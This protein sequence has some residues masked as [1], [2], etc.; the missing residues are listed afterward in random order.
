MRWEMT[1]GNPIT[2]VRQC[3]R[4]SGRPPRSHARSVSGAAEIASL[5]WFIRETSWTLGNVKTPR[6]PSASDRQPG[7]PVRPQAEAGRAARLDVVIRF[8]SSFR[9]WLAWRADGYGGQVQAAALDR[10]RLRR[11]RRARRRSA[12]A[13]RER[14]RTRRS[15][16]SRA[17]GVPLRARAAGP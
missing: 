6:A 9:K 15:R 17:R 13:A 14:R 16:R 10:L 7:A 11:P 4:H 8:L 2:L 3:T 12:P 1:E 5:G